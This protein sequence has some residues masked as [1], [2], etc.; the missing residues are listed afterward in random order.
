VEVAEILETAS[1]FVAFGTRRGAEV[2]LKIAK[3]V[4]DEWR[5][6]EVLRAFAGNGTVRVYEFDFGA[7]L[8]ERLRPG[9][10]LLSLV[11][12]GEDDH[13]SLILANL[14]SQMAGHPAPDSCPTVWDWS[15]AFERYLN[16]GDKR[17]PEELVSE[18]RIRYRTL[19]ASPQNETLLH[20]DLHHY[21]V[22]F[23]A[24]RGWVAIDPKGVVGEIE[25]EVGAI[26][27]N[28]V[29]LPELFNSVATIERRVHRFVKQLR[30]NRGRV[31]AWAFAQAVLSAIWDVE[32]GFEVGPEHH[33]LRLAKIIK[34]MLRSI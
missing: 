10:Q 29:Q 28:P 3:Q 11:L 20:G 22:L 31:I 5:S 25:Y 13:A 4:G 2:V 33:T 27:R 32:D 12:Q 16:S 9:T 17:I 26:L 34:P 23:D 21:N 18:A 7:V 1:S 8:L 19:A 6:G 14:M 30:L 24:K 15:A